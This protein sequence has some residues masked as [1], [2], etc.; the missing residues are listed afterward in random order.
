M[1]MSTGATPYRPKTNFERHM[2]EQMQT[3]V[4]HHSTYT[5]RLD[6]MNQEIDALQK[7][8]GNQN[9][10]DERVATDYEVE[11]EDDG[12][13]GSKE[14]EREQEETY[15]YLMA[16]SS[17]SESSVS[18]DESACT[19]NRYYQ[20]LDAFQEFYDEAMKLR[21]LIIKFR[22][23]NKRLENRLE[24]LDNENDS[25]KS[26][27]ESLENISQN[28]MHVNKNYDLECEICPRQLERIKYLM[29]TLSKF[30][31]GSSNLDP[32]LGSQRSVLNREGIRGGLSARRCR[33]PPGVEGQPQWCNLQESVYH[34]SP[35]PYFKCYGKTFVVKV[36][37]V[38]QEKGIVLL[39]FELSSSFYFRLGLQEEGFVSSACTMQFGQVNYMDTQFH[40]RN[41]NH[42]WKPHLNMGQSQ[43]GQAVGQFD[44]LPQ[45]QWQQQPSLSERMAKMNDTL[46]KLIQMFDSHHKNNQATFRRIGSQLGH[47]IQKLDDLGSPASITIQPRGSSGCAQEAQQRPE[48]QRPSS[49]RS[50][51]GEESP[52][53]IRSEGVERPCAREASN[54]P[55]PARIQRPTLHIKEAH[56]PKE[57]TTHW[58]V[59]GHGPAA[60]STHEGGAWRRKES[61]HSLGGISSNGRPFSSTTTL[62]IFKEVEVNIPQFDNAFN[63]YAID[64]KMRGGVDFIFG[65]AHR[66]GTRERSAEAHGP[67]QLNFGGPAISERR[68]LDGKVTSCT[69]RWAGLH[70]LHAA[71]HAHNQ[72]LIW[73]F[74]QLK[75][76]TLH[77]LM[78]AGQHLLRDAKRIQI[79]TSTDGC[80]YDE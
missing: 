79:T 45:Q 63:D 24:V 10:G 35:L 57:G 80:C 48:I 56:G 71:L 23:E 50:C 26:K 14:N 29:K 46:Q 67:R 4:N 51:M 28:T 40:Q 52:M 12:D 60:S 5:S 17:I 3:L 49:S 70:A 27:L 20:L 59:N 11:E 77:L 30:N 19:E 39:K 1:E 34:Y 8:I 37:R 76:R 18:S 16:K 44:R 66:D 42:W 69:R 36:V 68:V 38:S 25:L 73:T 78:D 74:Q 32:L 13:D 31:L 65:G 22:K 41:F 62:P 6:K 75:E 47:I 21:H 43:F 7:L 53:M 58:E 33:T 9:L 72:L 2:V 64:S 55:G 54:N 15:F 61:L